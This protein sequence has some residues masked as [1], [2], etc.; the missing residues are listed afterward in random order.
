MCGRT[1]CTLGQKEICMACS[2]KSSETGKYVQPEWK[3]STD[4]KEYCPSYNMPPTHHTPVLISKMHMDKTADHSERLLQPMVWGLIPFWHKD[5]DPQSHGLST[6]NCRSEGLMEKKTF[7]VPIKKGRRCVVVA[8]GFYEWEKKKTGK[9]P[10][11]FYFPQR[12]GLSV[13]DES[14][15]KKGYNQELWSPKDGWK[16]PR[17]LTIAGLFDVWKSPE[18]EKLMYSYCVIT[19]PSSPKISWV[20]HRMPAILDGPE[21]VQAWL[22]YEDVD[23]SNALKLVKPISNLEWHAV[24]PAVGNVKNDSVELVKHYSSTS[25]KKLVGSQKLMSAWLQKESP[26]KSPKKE[27]PEHNAMKQE[28][29]DEWDAD[30]NFQ[31]PPCQGSDHEDEE[32]PLKKPKAE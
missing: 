12:R 27:E 8:D 20:H 10:Y 14:T 4:G 28:L 11:L 26:K 15:W 22:N 24:S 16:G 13:G 9:Q 25:G 2:Y 18:T 29:P 32:P 1:A 3:D 23:A 7:S 5:A 31:E 19:V 17:V 30:G 6:I 21:E